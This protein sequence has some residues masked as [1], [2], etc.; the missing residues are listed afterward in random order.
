[1]IEQNHGLALPRALQQDFSQ[2]VQQVADAENRE[3]TQAA[4]WQLFRRVYGI[5]APTLQLGEYRSES[6][7]QG[8]LR[9]EAGIRQGDRYDT[10]SGRGNG[11]LSAA[12][13]A[14]RQSLDIAFTIQD[15]HEHTLG[16]RS[17]SRSV[18]YLR[19]IFPGNRSAWGVGID[20]DVS[21]ASL[22]ALLNAVAQHQP[23]GK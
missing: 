22:Q 7:S 19:C 3:M 12:A 5:E 23:A 16:Q 8:A 20:S 11:L 4:I 14:L 9:F 18:T 15:Y 10:I 13:D 2:Q 17:D 6:D 21:R 1:M